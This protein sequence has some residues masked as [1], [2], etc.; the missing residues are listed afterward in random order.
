MTSKQI[1]LLFDWDGVVIDSHQ[2]HEESWKLLADEL[3]SSL[4]EGFFKATFGMR[5]QQILPMW[6]PELQESTGEIARLGDRK[7]ELYRAILRRDGIQALPGVKTFLQAAKAAGIPRSVGSSTPRKNIETVIEMAGL[8]GLFD[9]IVC[10]EDVQ[11]GKPDPEVFLLGAQRLGCAP[12]NCIVFED[13]F[14]G[15]AAGLAGGM[16]VVGI[17]TTH[18]IEKLTDAHISLTSLEGITPES[19]SQKLGLNL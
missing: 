14:V 5:N 13:A 10:A 12:E 18:P 19:L 4:P 6:F 8:E 9:V 16:K 2:A 3:G 11:R 15:I 17:A 7:E 1:G